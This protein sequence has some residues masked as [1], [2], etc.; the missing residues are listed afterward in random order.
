MKERALTA[1]A[2]GRAAKIAKA[3]AE[4][5][6]VSFTLERF[7]VCVG[8]GRNELLRLAAAPDEGLSSGELALRDKLREIC[9]DAAAS[10]VEH[11]MTRG[12]AAMDTFLLKANFGYGDAAANVNE[13]PVIITGNDEILE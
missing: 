6:G 4:E 10:H 5:H 1:Q 9:A 3:W 7:A 12:S 13:L 8:R 2:A 11:G